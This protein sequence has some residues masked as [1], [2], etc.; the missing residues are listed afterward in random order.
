MT[1]WSPN[2]WEKFEA[3]Q[4]PDFDLT[5]LENVFKE[6][7]SVPP[8]VFAG[9]T[10]TL[11]KSLADV[12]KGK[13]FILQAGDCAESFDAFNSPSIREKLRVILQ[14]AVVLTYSSGV[15]CIKI[16]R[17]AGQ[18]AKPRS[19]ETETRDGVT[20]PS[21]RGDIIN[22]IEFT[23]A[24]RKAD[25]SRLLRGY[26]QSAATLNLLRAFTKGGFADLARVN[27][28]NQEF[29]AST[30]EGHRYNQIADEIT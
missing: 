25:A 24:A 7:S 28:W 16:G 30:Q 8:L 1:T 15:P 10:R 29:V 18:F 14:M 27:A 17:I 20:L 9:E 12:E 3:K 19:E 22:D 6:L 4:Q 21:Y 5:E 13:G 2:S 26:N 23:E 11:R